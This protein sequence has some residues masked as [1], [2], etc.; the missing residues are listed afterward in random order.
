MSR[1]S[2]IKEN[3]KKLFESRLQLKPKLG[4][5]NHQ[6][7][8]ENKLHNE[9]S[10]IL[11][12]S[13]PFTQ[14]IFKKHLK[15]HSSLE[16]SF[17]KNINNSLLNKKF[18]K[19]NID[20]KTKSKNSRIKRNQNKSNILIKDI[21]YYHFKN[22]PKNSD[23]QN[24]TIINV[25]KRL[26]KKKNSRN[27]NMNRLP[28]EK[29]D[30]LGLITLNIKKP[31][32]SNRNFHF[33]N[34]ISRS[35]TT[36][37][38]LNKNIT[39]N[40]SNYI[41]NNTNISI[42]NFNNGNKE[43]LFKEKLM[44]KYK[45]TNDIFI[46]IP[47]KI[48]RTN[49]NS[50]RNDSNSDK[51]FLRNNSIKIKKIKIKKKPSNSNYAKNNFRNRLNDLILNYNNNLNQ[52]DQNSLNIFKNNINNNKKT[53]DVY[54]DS[55]N[56]QFFLGKYLGKLLQK[57]NNRIIKNSQKNSLRKSHFNTNTLNID[58]YNNNFGNMSNSNRYLFNNNNNYLKKLV[59]KDNNK[60]KNLSRNIKNTYINKNTYSKKIL[61]QELKPLKK[62]MN[63]KDFND[64]IIFQKS[65]NIDI[66]NNNT[67]NKRNKLYKEIDSSELIIKDNNNNN[68]E[69]DKSKIKDEFFSTEK[70]KKKDD[71]TVE[72]DSGI[73]SIN[74]V[75]DIITYNNMSHIRKKDNFL[76][77]Y[78]DY[79]DFIKLHR[80]KIC[81]MFFDNKDNN[82]FIFQPRKKTIISN[83]SNNKEYNIKNYIEF[84]KISLNNSIKKKKQ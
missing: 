68:E 64:K 60:D 5:K 48:Y 81:N 75:E 66:S 82:K 20:S 76:F 26:M 36:I 30:R 32:I 21:T 65:N 31:K 34:S 19:I 54:K 80:N 16:S 83:I 58:K 35:M 4:N 37:N 73:L 28:V 84:K 2:I 40:N 71:S 63:K 15:N 72:E 45:L 39:I 27:I 55:K 61:T 67:I 69:K 53:L 44:P 13:Q 23:F 50:N 70:N 47:N 33:T 42:N 24:K 49:L 41:M 9:N 22:S 38:K 29:T 25:N 57:N 74:Q 46:K 17:L 56:R 62:N 59:R 52:R 7:Y 18:I 10:S 78:N 3:N 6:I 12:Y 77:N 1:N 79:N 14:D 51:K 43:I 11:N 8:F